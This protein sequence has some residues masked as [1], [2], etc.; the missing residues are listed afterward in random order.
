M[1][2]HQ[3]RANRM[4]PGTTEK[5]K[6]V[7]APSVLRKTIYPTG[8]YGGVL[9]SYYDRRDSRQRDDREALEIS[10]RERAQIEAFARTRGI[11]ADVVQE[12]LAVVHEHD[13]FP[14][15]KGVVEQR[16]AQTLEA[17]RIKHG[18]HEEAQKVV[19][20]YV[21]LTAELAKEVPTLAARVNETGAG[22]D[23]RIITAL[24][25]YGE[26]TQVKE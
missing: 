24:A 26:P 15:S 25:Q 17:L 21:A 8:G 10:R 12:T 16:R 9:S 6:A 3:E 13:M 11:P 2:S 23:M 18:G 20:N 14:K 4:Y 5:P 22:E 7:A 1:S 19:R